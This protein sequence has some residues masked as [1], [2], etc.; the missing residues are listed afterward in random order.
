MKKAALSISLKIS[1]NLLLLLVSASLSAQRPIAYYPFNNNT[2]DLSGNQNNGFIYGNVT[3]IPDRF[4]NPCSAYYFDG[5]TGY[6]RIPSSNSLESPRT[7]LTICVWYKLASIG[8]PQLWLTSVC[9][10][11]N[12]IEYDDNPQYRMQIQ[13][14]SISVLNAC[15]IYAPSPSSTISMCTQLTAC[16]D[17]FMSHPFETNKWHFYCMTYDGSDMKAYMDGKMVFS[18][19]F[20]QSLEPNKSPLYIGLDEPGNNEYFNGALDDIRLYNVALTDKEINGLFNEMGQTSTGAEFELPFQSNIKVYSPRYACSSKAFFNIKQPTS[21]C[22]IVKLSQTEGLPSGAEFQPGRNKVV[23]EALS[24]SSYKEVLTFYV[25]VKDTVP[26]DVLQPSDIIINLQPGQTDTEL[27]YSLPNVTDNCQLTRSGIISGPI[28]G[29]RLKP[30]TYPISFEAEDNSGNRQIVSWKI[31]VNPVSKPLIDTIV[32]PSPPAIQMIDSI[33]I[34]KNTT[35]PPLPV[36]TPI[37]DSNIIYY[38]KD[39]LSVNY[40]PNNILFLIDVS[41]S[42]LQNDK[43]N[44]LKTAVNNIV[45]KLRAIDRITIMT[46]ADT[47]ATVVQYQSVADKK[48]LIKKISTIHASGGTEAEA[49][50]DEVYASMKSNY[51]L[52]GNNDIYM[53]TDGLF[54]LGKKQ[55]KIIQT[56]SNNPDKRVTLNILAFGNSAQSLSDLRTI[57][58]WGRGQFLYVSNEEEATSL[59]LNQIKINSKK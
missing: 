57:S 43:I 49:A 2:K 34:V 33:P 28:S 4:G 52:D 5:S 29:T 21:T 31:L 18:T 36:M 9:K 7:R 16:D 24:S 15:S 50:I 20:S 25:E 37:N 11:E 3:P 10:G 13:Q 14:N 56:F 59:I 48:F 53:A 22:G 55:K 32:T 1:F 51:L 41:S 45:K 19:P 35:T 42:M 17:Q 39:T 8:A 23:F 27:T 26:P 30:G 6:I 46:Y 47:V 44:I 12:S 38:D 40:K 58:D 54:S